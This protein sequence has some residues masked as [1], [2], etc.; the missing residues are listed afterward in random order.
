MERCVK[1]ELLDELP[2]DDPRA[3]RSRKD[4]VRVNAWMG[5]CGIMARELRST[6]NGRA[7]RRMVDVGAGDGRFLLRVARR[8][9][10]DW[11]GTHAVLLDAQNAVSP[12]THT[13]FQTLGWRTET[14]EADA[15]DWLRQPATPACDVLIANLFLHH[16]REAQLAGLLRAAVRSTRVFIAIEPRRAARS[17]LFSHLLWIIGC[18]QVTRHDAVVSIRA[19]FTGRELSQVWPADQGWALQERPVGWFSHLFIAQRRE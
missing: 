15:L 10:A 16:F 17:L 14:R 1:P 4:L 7:T 2:P 12:D 8:L 18:N 5:N 6:C 9:R 11:R 19:G 13:A 3:V